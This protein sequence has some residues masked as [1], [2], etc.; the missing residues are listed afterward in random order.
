LVGLLSG[1]I[2]MRLFVFDGAGKPLAPQIGKYVVV[3][4]FAL[5]QTLIISVICARWLL[6]AMGVVQYAEALA[7]LVGVLVP[8]V[9]SYFGHKLLT[10]R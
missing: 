1:F 7:H 4:L 9:T 3:N 2:L 8:V 10:F 6:P 5:A